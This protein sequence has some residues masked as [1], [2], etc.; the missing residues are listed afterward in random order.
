MKF[1]TVRDAGGRE[2]EITEDEVASYRSMGFK[3]VDGA[4]DDRP[5]SPAVAATQPLEP[6]S[7]TDQRLDLVLEELRGLRAD[8][9]AFYA[10]VEIAELPAD[11][12]TI[13][14]REPA[15]TKPTDSAARPAD[16]KATDAK[17]A[18]KK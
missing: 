4:V 10:P 1:V 3:P 16:A 5:G 12:E 18:D 11:G 7:G 9:A 14:L 8:F 2:A 6:A 17:A 15:E 13:Q